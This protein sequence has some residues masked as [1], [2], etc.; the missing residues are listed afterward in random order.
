MPRAPF[1]AQQHGFAFSNSF[2]NHVIRIDFL[3]IDV[4]TRGRCG[5]MAYASLDYWSNGLAVPESSNLPEDGTLLGD[6]IYWR[7]IDSMVA[8]GLKFFHFMRT[9]DHPT[10]INGIGVARATREEEF[11]R[12]K[13][14]IDSRRPCALGLTQ[15]R[16]IGDLGNDHQVVATG[17]EDGDPYSKVFIYDNNYPGVESSLTFKTA[18]DPGEREITHSS[19]SVWRGFF[20][21]AHAPQVPWYL[22]DGRLLS[23]QSDPAIHV[24]RSGGRLHIASPQEFD[25]NGFDWNAV[26]EAK[27]GSMAHIATFPANRALVR[28]RS[29]APV[30]VVYGGKGFHIPTPEVFNA[31]GLDWGSVRTIPDGSLGGLRNIPRDGTLLKEQSTAAVYVMRG[32]QLRGIPSAEEFEARG[33]VWELIGV[34]PDGSLDGIPVGPNLEETVVPTTPVPQSWAERSFGTVYTADGDEIDFSIQPGAKDANEVEFVLV[35]G[36]NLT[37]NKELVLREGA[38]GEWTIPVTKDARSAANGLY[39]DQLPGGQLRFRKAKTFGIMTDV[40]G[41][42]NLEQ[43][44]VGAQVTFTWRTD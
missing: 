23:D 27:D 31:L 18:Y 15:A 3:N 41:L 21:E 37:W 10:W 2:V 19:G 39:R 14:L 40:H 24:V 22:P 6:Y 30:Y 26:L 36:D 42:G 29:S 17:Y 8:N 1:T 11:P 12:L 5:G 4:T 28:E 34:V 44:P 13:Q 20:V 16:S 38:G 7:L 35:L 33:F 25:A 32:G 9:P 43:L